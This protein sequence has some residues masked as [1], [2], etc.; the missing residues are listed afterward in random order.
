MIWISRFSNGGV[1]WI[2]VTSLICSPSSSVPIATTEAESPS[3][4]GAPSC[5][6]NTMIAAGAELCGNASCSISNAWI[7]S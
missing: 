2:A 1:D 3:V 5:R 6:A 7:D 4:S